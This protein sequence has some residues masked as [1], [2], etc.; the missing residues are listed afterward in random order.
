M[1]TT[2]MELFPINISLC[3]VNGRAIATI[4]SIT[5]EAVFIAVAAE[6]QHREV[7]QK[8]AAQLRKLADKFEKLSQQKKPLQRNV[9]IEI[10]G[11]AQ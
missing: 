9:Q 4:D 10:N 6:G 5:H 2:S 7:A 3:R 11:G 8:A 1:S